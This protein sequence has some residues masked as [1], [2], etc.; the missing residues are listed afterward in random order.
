MGWL[1]FK[2]AECQY[3]EY[4]RFLTDQFISGLNDGM[5]IHENPKEMATLTDIECLYMGKQSRIAKG[6]KSAFNGIKE[7][8][9]FDFI[10]QHMLK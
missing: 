7:V 4:D 5:M 6:A 1:W 10:K 2:A 8:N 9:D 3:K